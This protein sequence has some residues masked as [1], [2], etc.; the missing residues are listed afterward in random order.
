MKILIIEDEKKSYVET[1]EKIMNSYDILP[2]FV[3]EDKNAF[4]EMKT[5]LVKGTIYD[6]VSK[7]I[8]ENYTELKLIICDLQLDCKNARGV[9]IIKKI[10]STIDMKNYPDFNK[11]IPIIALTSHGDEDITESA[12]N[13]GADFYIHKNNSTYLKAVIDNQCSKFDFLCKKFILQ[14]R[15]KV[16]LTFTG[17]QRSLV[18]TVAFK[19]GLEYSK[20]KVFYDYF[21][22]VELARLDLDTYLQDIYLNKC[23]FIVVFISSDYEGREWCG[24]VEFRSIRELIKSGKK[25]KV[26]LIK[27]ENVDIK[28]IFSFDG[29][30]DATEG[31]KN[32]DQIAQE[33]IECIRGGFK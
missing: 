30:I 2:Q 21:H 9:D 17:K 14:N 32:E 25:D 5:S 1:A 31:I 18:N 23:E 4:N 11:L 6:Y 7:I 24:N 26:I 10:R 12:L 8:Q 19:L 15:F 28:T 27:L 33:I 22:K 13:A 16:G 29:F 20:D 3:D